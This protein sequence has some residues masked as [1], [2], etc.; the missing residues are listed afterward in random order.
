MI[1]VGHNFGGFEKQ[2]AYG[3]E[4]FGKA[5]F[6]VLD[7]GHLPYLP[8]PPTVQCSQDCASEQCCGEIAKKVWGWLVSQGVAEATV[9]SN[10]GSCCTLTGLLAALVA[11]DIFPPMEKCAADFM[12]PSDTKMVVKDPKMGVKAPGGSPL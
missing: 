1:G 7:L 8:G 3:L 4:W 12:V 6:Q 11:E 9:P 10:V 5:S 2:T